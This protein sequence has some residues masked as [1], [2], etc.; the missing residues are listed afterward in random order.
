MCWI[1]HHTASSAT[2]SCSQQNWFL[3]DRWDCVSTWTGESV[4]ICFGG[5]PCRVYGR[6]SMYGVNV[7]PLSYTE[8][9][10]S[11]GQPVVSI[12]TDELILRRLS[13]PSNLYQTVK[14]HKLYLSALGLSS[15][16]E[17]FII[18]KRQRAKWKESRQYDGTSPGTWPNGCLLANGRRLR[19]SERA[20]FHNA[21]L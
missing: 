13:P 14:W 1:A 5:P 10:N 2:V 19:V 12:E 9:I 8:L 21:R 18:I 6:R 17:T 15:F 3:V 11:P 7:S 4:A 20:I 16:W